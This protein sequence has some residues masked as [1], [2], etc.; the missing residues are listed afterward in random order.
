[1]GRSMRRFCAAVATAAWLAAA[2][3]LLGRAA[4]DARANPDISG[5][6]E[7]NFDSRQVTQATLLPTVTR[8]KIDAHAKKAAYDV[9]WC[10][11]L[12]VPFVMDSGRPLD[13]R[14]GTTAVIIA[15]EN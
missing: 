14:Q 2:P 11:L 9:R 4:Q 8:A 13:I 6:W 10:N 15:P 12:G 5:F 7:L 3:P 1:M